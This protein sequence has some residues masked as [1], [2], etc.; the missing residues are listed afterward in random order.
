MRAS[1]VDLHEDSSGA[2]S[3]S[4]RNLLSVITEFVKLF[5]GCE[6]LVQPMPRVVA[7]AGGD[8]EQHERAHAHDNVVPFAGVP[9][10]KRSAQSEVRIVP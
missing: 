6:V 7:L 5:D 3:G 8:A 10:N 9:R 1:G 2:H 4:L